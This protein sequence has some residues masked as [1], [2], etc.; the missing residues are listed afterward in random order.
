MSESDLTTKLKIVP[1]SVAPMQAVGKKHDEVL[2]GVKTD[3]KY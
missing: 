1:Q 3:K 2:K